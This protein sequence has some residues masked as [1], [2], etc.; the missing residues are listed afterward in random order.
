MKDLSTETFYEKRTDKDW[1]MFSISV[2]LITKFEKTRNVSVSLEQPFL[3]LVVRFRKY[4]LR[5]SRS[6]DL[7]YGS[8]SGRQINYESG[9]IRILPGYFVAMLK[10][11]I[12]C[13]KR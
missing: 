6:A 12:C 4:F 7:N 11:Y 1:I 9:R 2:K 10:K 3:K 13:K 5:I 8:G